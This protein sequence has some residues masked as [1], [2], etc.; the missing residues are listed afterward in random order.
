MRILIEHQSFTPQDPKHRVE[1]AERCALKLRELIRQQEKD[2]EYRETI[3]SSAAKASRETY[4]SKL[5]EL[6]S[7]F[8][9]AIDLPPQKRGYALEELF[10]ELMRISGVP[11]CHGIIKHLYFRMTRKYE[12]AASRTLISKPHHE[13]LEHQLPN[14]VE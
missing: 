10:T 6:R 1:V 5:G 13:L 8:V 9:D 7:K 11:V 4:E 2:R 14:G 12:D 3:R